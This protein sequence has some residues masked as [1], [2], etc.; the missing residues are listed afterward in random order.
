MISTIETHSKLWNN[1]VIRLENGSTDE[2]KEQLKSRY[3][4]LMMD[5]ANEIKEVYV[6]MLNDGG[7]QRPKHQSMAQRCL[8]ETERPAQVYYFPNS[9]SRMLSQL[10]RNS[11]VLEFGSHVQT[12][13]HTPIGQ[14]HLYSEFDHFHEEECPWLVD[15]IIEVLN[16]HLIQEQTQQGVASYAPSYLQERNQQDTQYFGPYYQLI[17]D[18][19]GKFF[20]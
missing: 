19:D 9:N 4:K 8:N 16:G 15:H 18:F 3:T 7:K 20:S 6:Q 2:E 14:F 17:K 1:Q 10:D 12:T 11:V 13:L 5:L